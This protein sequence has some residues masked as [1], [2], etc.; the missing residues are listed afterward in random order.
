[1]PTIAEKRVEW[2]YEHFQAISRLSDRILVLFG[3]LFVSSLAVWQSSDQII[4]LPFLKVNAGRQ[5]LLGCTI[6]SSVFLLVAFFGN[7]DKGEATLDALCGELGCSWTDIWFVDTHPTLFDFA[8]FRRPEVAR[9]RWL[10]A[11]VGAALLYPLA[12]LSGLAWLTYVFGY[13]LF[14]RQMS[15]METV[16]YLLTLPLL[17]VAWHRGGEYLWRRLKS[18]VRTE[19]Q[20]RVKPPVV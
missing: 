2:L 14:V 6:L 16:P 5:V 13:E 1:M 10:P 18:F 19:R 15:K 17:Y 9:K 12:L 7:Y 20:R 8:Q 4:E 11:R 3:I